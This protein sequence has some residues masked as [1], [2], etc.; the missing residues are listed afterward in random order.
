MVDIHFSVFL[1]KYT[2]SIDDSSVSKFLSN[3]MLSTTLGLLLHLPLT[4]ALVSI[5]NGFDIN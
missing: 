5:N 1:G 4:I 2:K 3:K